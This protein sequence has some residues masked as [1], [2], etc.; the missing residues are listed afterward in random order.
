MKENIFNK[1]LLST[2]K[3]LVDGARKS[4]LAL[5]HLIAMF[6]ATVLVPLLTGLDPSISLF[7]AGCG[8]LIF[9]KITDGK[10]PV[11]LGSSFA[12]I[13]VVLEVNNM[14]NGDLSYAQG[15]ML[16]AGVIYVLM[17][18]VVEKIGLDRIQKYLGPQIV[19]P[20]IIVIGLNLIPTAL[21]M[22]SQNYMVAIITL[23]TALIINLKGEGLIKQLSILIA[24]IVGYT[25]SLNL[26]IVD[27]YSIKSS[28]VLSVPSFNLPK[29]DLAAILT[30]APVVLAV[31][32]EHLG[33][34]TTNGQVVGK[35][36]VENPG[37]NKTLLGDG[38]ATIF[39]TLI[40]GPA[41]T[42]Y[43]ENTGVLAI[44]KNYDPS[45]LRLAALFAIILSF[46]SKVGTI[47][48]TIPNAVMGG[49]SIMLFGMIS[50]VGVKTIRDDKKLYKNWK[51]ILVIVIILILGLGGDFLGNK[52]GII[53]GI[54]ITKNVSI[55]GLSF[56]AIIGILLNLILNVNNKQ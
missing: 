1:E 37:L 29:F 33:D 52:L 23:L 3:V 19:G 6:G 8:T 28:K 4:V 46:V 11:F 53:I 21:E 27:I 9:H 32:M 24:V 49:I 30:I 17:S 7:T 12:F 48:T 41:N 22:A 42:T 20:M 55:T 13:P 26:N 14:Y 47:L 54:P 56:A 34:I 35:N 45:I 2:N 5:Q 38:M 10:V 36:F 43:G 15:G 31:F 50:L 18:F 51:N 40:G 44:T 39:A 16:I 25:I